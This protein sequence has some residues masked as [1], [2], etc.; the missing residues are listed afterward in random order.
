MKKERNINGNRRIAF[1]KHI[2]FRSTKI[3]F[4]NFMFIIER[5]VYCISVIYNPYNWAKPFLN[6][7]IFNSIIKN[8]CTLITLTKNLLQL[9]FKI[10]YY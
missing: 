2:S 9:Q 8:G 7:L 6:E 1:T 5:L 3:I 10:F 4:K